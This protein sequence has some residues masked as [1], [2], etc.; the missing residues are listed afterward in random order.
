MILWIRVVR[1][2]PGRSKSARE[3][4]GI[5]NEHACMVRIDNPNRDDLL[6]L[7]K[8]KRKKK[9]MQRWKKIRTGLCQR[10]WG[11]TRAFTRDHD[12]S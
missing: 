9:K 10:C 4:A 5:M 11:V 1:D 7:L 12:G 6:P 8:R 3:S 2:T